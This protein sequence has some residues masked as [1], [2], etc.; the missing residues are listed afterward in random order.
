MREAISINLTAGRTILKIEDFDIIMKER[1]QSSDDPLDEDYYN[2]IMHEPIKSPITIPTA[3][4]IPPPEEC[5]DDDV[6]EIGSNFDNENEIEN[7][8]ANNGDDDVNDDVNEIENDI[9]VQANN[10][11]SR[12]KENGE[13]VIQNATC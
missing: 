6:N 12:K 4:A 8:H 13:D 7:D 2:N 3:A 5:N 11:D 9:D 1:P 10:G